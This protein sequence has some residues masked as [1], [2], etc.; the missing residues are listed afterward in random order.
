MRW[1][2]GITDAMKVK[3]GKLPEVV[4]DREARR[5]NSPWH[6]KAP[7]TTGQLNDNTETGCK[8]KAELPEHEAGQEGRCMLSHSAASDS[9]RP[10]GL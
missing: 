7:D 6:R 10:H 2:D 4:R 8:E 1:M 5:G 3:L 9:L